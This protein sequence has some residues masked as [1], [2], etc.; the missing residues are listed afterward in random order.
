MIDP[1][2][3]SNRYFAGL[4]DGIYQMRLLRNG[5]SE[6]DVAGMLDRAQEYVKMRRW[7]AAAEVLIEAIEGVRLPV[8]VEL[9]EMELA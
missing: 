5:M 6:S 3:N 2:G 4:E 8:M 7:E 1:W 9:P